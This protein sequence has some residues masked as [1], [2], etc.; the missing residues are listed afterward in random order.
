MKFYVTCV[1]I[2]ILLNEFDA[3][4]G[5]IFKR[6]FFIANNPESVYFDC[7]NIS[8]K[9]VDNC[10][11]S[12][13]NETFMQNVK[14]L[15]IRACQFLAFS[16]VYNLVA[17][18]PTNLHELDISNNQKKFVEDLLTAFFKVY[19]SLSRLN[20]S[21]CQL[22]AI[23]AEIFDRT[24]NLI[25]IDLSFNQITQNDF[26]SFQILTKLKTLDLSSNALG[27]LDSIAFSNLKSL[28]TSNRLNGIVNM[29]D[30]TFN[31]NVN[32]RIYTYFTFSAGHL[33]FRCILVISQDS[34]HAA[35]TMHL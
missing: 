3:L 33:Q 2:L 5:G 6:C 31:Q 8:E 20:A 17:S 12:I 16:S 25:E 26:N 23:R 27:S 1:L 29:A 9:N 32:L 28:E 4:F 34:T 10:S 14:L 21:Y 15:K 24:P 22:T 13:E 35:W 30:D 7:E 18:I 19:N 11:S